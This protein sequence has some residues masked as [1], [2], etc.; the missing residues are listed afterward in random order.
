MAV[1]FTRPF[2]RACSPGAAAAR[3]AARRIMSVMFADAGEPVSTQCLKKLADFL[4]IL[5]VH[6]SAHDL[7]GE[8]HESNA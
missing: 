1:G 5:L 6:C 7:S 3:S 8:V 2:T 4:N